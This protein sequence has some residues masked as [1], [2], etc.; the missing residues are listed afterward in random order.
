MEKIKRIKLENEMED[1]YYLKDPKLLELYKQCLPPEESYYYFPKGEEI[2]VINRDKPI[3]SVRRVFYN[4]PYT[5][6]EQ[7]WLKEFKQLL[8]SSPEI[9]LPEYFDDYFL[10]AFIYSSGGKLDD[11]KKRIIEYLKFVNETFPIR[12]TPNS[13]LIEI[14]NKG[15]IYVYGR[16]NRYRPII[17][18]QCKSFQKYY[19]N[20]QTEEL[21]QASSFLCQFIINNMLI[22]G[23]YET[24]NMIINVSGVSIISLPDPLK[25]LIPK[26]SNYFLC[27]LYKNYI[28]GL[29]FFSKILYKIAVNFIDK[30]TAEKIIVLDNKKDPALFK[31]IRPDNI[32]EQFGGV[33]PNL[34]PDEQNGLFPPRM[35]S[36]KFITDQENPSDILITEDEYINKYRNGEIPESCVSPYIYEK[37]K[38]PEK[39]EVNNNDEIQEKKTESIN[40]KIKKKNTV[41][42]T[43]ENSLNKS[44]NEK[45]LFRKKS[46]IEKKNKNYCKMKHFI[47]NGWNYNDE[48]PIPK[49]NFNTT[50]INHHTTFLNEINK[51]GK[52]KQKF[53]SNI[54]LFNINN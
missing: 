14:L 45:E 4:M 9:K 43:K 40:K 41:K 42:Q 38:V 34:N 10:L 1:P 25:K 3:K 15:F 24:W 31:A 29:N 19:K 26:L 28:I 8:N 44:I 33:A 48:Y 49:Y 36:Q 17:V 23:Q 6:D 37:L 39:I 46:Q 11:S 35:P 30:V 27:R 18:C 16:D 21:L 7:N 5:N 47:Y 22:P 13:K 53:F 54:S 32:E 20:Y 50:H 2:I 12:I 52:K 51:F